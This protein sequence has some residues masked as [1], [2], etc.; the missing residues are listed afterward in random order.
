MQRFHFNRRH[1][2]SE[3]RSD[4]KA[5]ASVVKITL[6]WSVELD[7]FFYRGI[8]MESLSNLTSSIDESQTS[9]ALDMYKIQLDKVQNLV[10]E[11]SGKGTFHILFH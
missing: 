2:T 10:E 9:D 11:F 6:L 1:Y 4:F 3:P 5:L 7:V 8:A